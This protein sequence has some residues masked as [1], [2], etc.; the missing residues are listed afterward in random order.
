MSKFATISINILST[1]QE[2]FDIIHLLET[3]REGSFHHRIYPS[4]I[5]FTP[6]DISYTI[7]QLFHGPV[8]TQKTPRNCKHQCV[9][10]RMGTIICRLEQHKEA[11]YCDRNRGYIAMLAVSK[12]HRGRVTAIFIQLRESENF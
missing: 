4:L 9:I 12:S 3:V 6:I 2:L 1:V 7:G 8:T 5:Q 11:R 10:R